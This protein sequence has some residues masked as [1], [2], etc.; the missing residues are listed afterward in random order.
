[1]QPLDISLITTFYSSM[2]RPIYTKTFQYS[3]KIKIIIEN[4]SFPKN[5]GV[6]EKQKSILMKFFKQD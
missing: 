4:I 1:M 5:E 6:A 2:V 3:F